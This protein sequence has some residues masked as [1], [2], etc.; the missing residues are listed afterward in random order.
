MGDCQ[1][2]EGAADLAVDVVQARIASLDVHQDLVPGEVSRARVEEARLRERRLGRAV[3]EGRVVDDEGEV[4][5]LQRR[6]LDVPGIGQVAEAAR[7]GR[8]ALVHAHL[9]LAELARHLVEVGGGVVVELEAAAGP[10]RV[11]MAVQLPRRAAVLLHLAGHLFP[12]GHAIL[13]VRGG[14]PIV[15]GSAV[16]LRQSALATGELVDVLA[17]LRHQPA[18]QDASA[19]H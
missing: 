14:V 7:L 16:A 10:R 11:E 3:L 9:R 13:T 19:A 4:R 2:G 6:P 17:A 12:Q 8:E 18:W 15:V 5:V 1:R